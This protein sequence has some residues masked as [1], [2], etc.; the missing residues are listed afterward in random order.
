[1]HSHPGVNMEECGAWPGDIIFQ[2]SSVSVSHTC[3]QTE[4]RIIDMEASQFDNEPLQWTQWH[5][6]GVIMCT[7]IC[8]S[9]LP[10]REIKILLL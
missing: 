2:G 1:M 6:H 5:H 10:L 8:H 7:H 3:T 4:Q 9:W